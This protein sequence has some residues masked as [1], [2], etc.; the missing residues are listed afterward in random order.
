MK[1]PFRT[2]WLTKSD[3]L[4]ILYLSGNFHNC[5]FV[6]WLIPGRFG[7]FPCEQDQTQYVIIEKRHIN[8]VLE[9]VLIINEFPNGLKKI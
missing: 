5:I 1:F 7:S 8:K 2:V 9:K 6:A 3:G 4:L